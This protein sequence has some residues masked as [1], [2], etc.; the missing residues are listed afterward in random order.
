M[1]PLGTAMPHDDELVLKEESWIHPIPID[2]KRISPT[3]I[4]LWSVVLDEFFEQQAQF[5]KMMSLT[6]LAYVQRLSP[7]TE[8]LRR[9][10]GFGLLRFVLSRYLDCMPNLIPV[11]LPANGKPRMSPEAGTGLLF[12]AVQ[13]E[14]EALFAVSLEREVG[15]DAAILHEADPATVEESSEL[16]QGAKQ[17]LLAMPP[18]NRTQAFHRFLTRRRALERARISQP[19][20]MAAAANTASPTSHFRERVS[21]TSLAAGRWQAIGFSVED[22]ESPEGFVAALAA[23][24][25]DWQVHTIRLRTKP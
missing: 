19:Q 17:L 11:D 23:E 24:R 18:K 9:I 5:M 10:A 2:V 25:H 20:A 21:L 12:D 16:S 4:H 13:V 22:L 8:Q 6:E 3:G 15:I 7:G 1:P 14:H